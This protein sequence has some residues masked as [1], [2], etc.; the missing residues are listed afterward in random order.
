MMLLH[1]TTKAGNNIR[2]IRGRTQK[3]STI[4]LETLIKLDEHLT[5]SSID[6]HTFDL[7]CLGRQSIIFIID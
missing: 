5:L 6:L 7:I 1:W 2:N 4:N 3:S